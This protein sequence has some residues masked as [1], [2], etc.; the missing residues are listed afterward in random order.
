MLFSMLCY[1]MLG[2]AMLCYAI[3]YNAVTKTK[4]AKRAE[5]VTKP[6]GF[7]LYQESGTA[8]ES[9]AK[10]VTEPCFFLPI[11]SGILN[12]G[13]CNF[14]ILGFGMLESGILEFGILVFSNL[15]FRNFGI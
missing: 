9:R 7:V 8:S 3:P 14:G 5:D 6:W 11:L 10:N 2:Y 15:D 12:F 1:A 13:I 4:F